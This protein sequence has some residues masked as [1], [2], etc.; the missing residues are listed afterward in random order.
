[1]Q[2]ERGKDRGKG[3]R[4]GS[5]R[6]DTKRRKENNPE[7]NHAAGKTGGGKERKVLLREAPEPRGL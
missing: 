1:M 6:V 3:A 7:K 4:E 5:C 2:S